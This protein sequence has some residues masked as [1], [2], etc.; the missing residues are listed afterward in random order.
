MRGTIFSRSDMLGTLD[1]FA[2]IP[3]KTLGCLA[4]ELPQGANVRELLISSWSD[5]CAA[6]EVAETADEVSFSLSTQAASSRYPLVAT[7]KPNT[8]SPEQLPWAVTYAGPD[9][10]H[11]LQSLGGSTQTPRNLYDFAFVD[12][13]QVIGDVKGRALPETW[14]FVE[15]DTSILRSYLWNTYQR[16]ALQEKVLVS[17]EEDLAA[18]NSGLVTTTY[19][20]LYLCFGSNSQPTPAWKYAGLCVAGERGLG[21]RLISVFPTPPAVATYVDDV[22]DL[23]M[24][25]T[26][27][28]Y[29][30]DRHILIDNVDRLPLEFL[31][32]E[33]YDQP[34]LLAQLDAIDVLRAH[35]ANGQDK[36]ELDTAYDTLRTSIE[37][38]A[39]AFR[40][41]K[42]TLHDAIDLARKRTRWSYRTAIPCYHPAADQ[43]SLLIP[44]YLREGSKP[45]VALVVSLRESGNYQ[46]ETILTMRQAYLDARLI[47]RPEEDWLT[48]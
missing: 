38:N 7:L 34:D 15:G 25:D 20:D 37:A 29:T 36:G 39:P 42:G 5:A 33:L 4:R 48:I 44:L 26:R 40:R 47:C 8:R 46:G 41:L 18:F 2:L 35:N 3:Q 13:T 1:E 11:V 14:G 32:K 19:D 10:H 12:W 45:D 9:R 16:A 27:E 6:G 17:V 43:M 22:S 31:R 24:D 21:K 30:D 23:V 28:L